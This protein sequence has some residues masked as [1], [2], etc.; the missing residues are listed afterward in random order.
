MPSFFFNDLNNCLEDVHPHR[1]VPP[2][3]S[4]QKTPGGL[5]SSIPPYDGHITHAGSIYGSCFRRLYHPSPYPES[6]RQPVQR[7]Q[8]PTSSRCSDCYAAT[9][10]GHC[11][12]SDPLPPQ[13]IHH[14]LSHPLTMVPSTTWTYIINEPPIFHPPFSHLAHFDHDICT[15]LLRP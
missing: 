4:T 5:T 1:P 15:T 2:N 10:N 9:V 12:S 3:R 6:I 13:S 14:S 11:L 7:A 8:R